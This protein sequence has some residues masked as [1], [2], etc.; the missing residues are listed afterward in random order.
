M[1]IKQ[2]QVWL[3]DQQLDAYIHLHTDPH[4]SEY[5][6]DH[7]QA[8][9]W[10][11]GFTGSAGTVVITQDQAALWADS[12]YFIQAEHELNPDWIT[13]M[14]A[15]EP[16]TPGINQWLL[17]Q[18]GRD[19]I[20]GVDAR[21]ITVNGFRERQAALKKHGITLI[22]VAGLL[23][24][25]WKDRPPQ[26]RK[27]II[28]HEIRYAGKSREDK[29]SEVRARM[30][31]QNA[32][33]LLIPSL[34]D[35]AWLLNLRGSD[36][37]FNPVFMSYLLVGME[38]AWLFVDEYQLSAE[39]AEELKRAGVQLMP[40][41]AIEE[42]LAQLEEDDLIWV[43]PARN[44]YL[45]FETIPEVVPRRELALPT[46]L[47]KARK[48]D[49]EQSL[50]RSCHVK[51]GVAMV[52]FLAW[53]DR[54]VEHESITELSAADKLNAFR[55]EQDLYQ[56]QSFSPIPG[57]GPHGALPHYRVTPESNAN[58]KP[59]GLFLIDSGGQYL[60]GT[61]DITRT[62]ALGPVTDQMKEDFTR[63]LRGH[64]ALNRAIFPKGTQGVQLDALAR[65]PLWAASLNYG[66]GTGHG[67]G[68]FLNVHE[69]PCGIGYKVR[70]QPALQPGMILSNE[71]G[72]YRSGAYGIRIENLI[73]VCEHEKNEFG[74][75][76]RF[77]SL[78]L[79]PIDTRLVIRSMMNPGEIDW[80]NQYHD[81]VRST[82]SPHLEGEDLEWLIKVTRD[83]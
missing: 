68:F 18:T 53:L 31:K 51:D 6:A 40:Y 14:K 54:N 39:I 66:H 61:T 8:M 17:D 15:G 71:P 45:L 37:E 35:I 56:G 74:Q 7:W 29:L 16:G 44:N 3:Q 21:L 76:Y 36:I 22:P 1:N 26:V 43:D 42:E 75:F 70:S 13:L 55:A 69:G 60:D 64:I 30:K 47:M 12:R 32:Q 28:N 5:L 58:L 62:V 81:S 33:F 73:L 63:V 23:E 2:A 79:C 67:V 38:L 19:S 24:E 9:S 11:T 72:L 10:L 27:A 25:I 78:T 46:S 48:N 34:D 83:L 65:Q 4:K 57:Y 82:L 77:E 50:S 59:E 20:V 52:R 49:T 80:L 41:S